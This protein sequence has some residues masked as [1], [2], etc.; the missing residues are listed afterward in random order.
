MRTVVACLS[1]LEEA[2]LAGQVIHAPFYVITSQETFENNF[3][4]GCQLLSLVY[5]YPIH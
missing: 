4:G 3:F 2:R 5:V 1:H